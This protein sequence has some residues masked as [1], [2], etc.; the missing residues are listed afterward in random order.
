LEFFNHCCHSRHYFF[1]IRKCGIETCNICKPIRSDPETFFKLH[2]LPDPIPIINQ[3]HY[4]QFEDVYGTE[5][6]ED[7]RPSLQKK[8]VDN[9]VTNDMGFSPSGQYAANTG[10]VI[11]C[12]ECSK[13]RVLY[14]KR[15][16]NT[17]ENSLLNRFL[18]SIE[19]TCGD[20]FNYLIAD[21]GNSND[22][23]SDDVSD[24]FKHVKVNNKLNCNNSMEVSYYSC[25]LYEDLCFLCGI[26]E[27]EETES[28]EE[29]YY[30]CSECSVGI[31]D[32]KKR[33]KKLFSGGSQS[34]RG[35]L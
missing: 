12:C 4:K 20:S 33:K 24:L 11:Q 7:F 6:T 14:C 25:N 1:E 26:N 13:W 32:K 5:T 17:N 30:Y 19:Y 3:E 21:G 27:R 10:T 2:N 34:K 22:V 18:D 29:C 35:R 23:E 28:Q 16:L 31:K 8:G 9:K 15:K